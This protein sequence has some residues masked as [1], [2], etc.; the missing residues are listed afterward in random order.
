MQKFLD[1]NRLPYE[2]VLDVDVLGCRTKRASK[3]F[4]KAQVKLAIAT[5]GKPTCGP[6]RPGEFEMDCRFCHREIG[7][8]G[9]LRQHFI[10]KHA[11]AQQTRVQMHKDGKGYYCPVKGCP[12]KCKSPLTLKRH[13]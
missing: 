8:P 12:K 4:T 7:A 9:V 6:G 1:D 3:A 2:L 10:R 13:Y 5:G 11:E